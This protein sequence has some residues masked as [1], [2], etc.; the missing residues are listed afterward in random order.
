MEI[1]CE[2]GEDAEDEGGEE[3]EG[4]FEEGVG[5]EESG[6]V[7]AVIRELAVE[8]VAFGGIDSDV[9]EHADYAEGGGYLDESL[10]CRY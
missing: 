9:L 1:N 5:G 6:D 2:G 3:V 4:K 7:V 10:D 8:D